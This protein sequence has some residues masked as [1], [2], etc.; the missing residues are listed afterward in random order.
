MFNTMNICG[1]TIY[2]IN[3][4]DFVASV[5]G[6]CAICIDET[7]KD[8]V[9]E[10]FASSS[11]EKF[12]KEKN[13][14]AEEF[15][16]IV[17]NLENNDISRTTIIAMSNEL[18]KDLSNDEILYLFH[19]ERGHIVNGDL[20]AK[21]KAIQDKEE[22]ADPVLMEIAADTYAITI[23]GIPAAVG[24]SALFKALRFGGTKIASDEEDLNGY[25]KFIETYPPVSRRIDNMKKY[26]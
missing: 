22:I 20:E 10:A 23:G 21:R 4:A 25:M 5:G 12:L 3:D 13:I 16:N 18:V 11:L 1:T 7:K 2:Q 14:T 8:L 15:G 6:A 9:I 17:C 26:L 24:I 19:H